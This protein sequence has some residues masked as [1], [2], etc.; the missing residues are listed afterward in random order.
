MIQQ[1]DMTQPAVAE[2]VLRVQLPAY[3]VEA[4]LIGFDGIPQLRDTVQTLMQ[5]EETFYGYAADGT[6]AGV[7]AVEKQEDV[8]HITRLVVHPDYFR[9]GIGRS[10]VQYALESEPGIRKFAVSTGAKNGSAISLYK[11]FGFAETKDVEVAPQVFITI[12]EK[13]V[14]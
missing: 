9:R 12:L 10:L 2:Q 11:Q 5:A 14:N 13:E 1:L 6:L 3:R 8:L 7:I 4:E